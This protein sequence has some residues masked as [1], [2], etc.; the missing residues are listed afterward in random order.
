M[1]PA[2]FIILKERA[3]SSIPRIQIDNCPVNTGLSEI[4]VHAHP[5]LMD[6]QPFQPGPQ[7]ASNPAEL[8]H[9]LAPLLQC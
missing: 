8:L 6:Q 3:A 2:I 4:K 7:L 9:W 1:I 5:E